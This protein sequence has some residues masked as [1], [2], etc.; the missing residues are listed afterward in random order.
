ME[1]RMR[2]LAEAVLLLHLGFIVFVLIGALLVARWRWLTVL[3]L[4]AVLW[5]LFIEISGGTC[6]L[7]PAENYF[8]HQAGQAGY[9][10]SFI[11]HYLVS[12]IYPAGLTPA[13]QWALAAVVLM[14]NLA[15]YGW[16]LLRHRARSRSG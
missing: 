7:T 9:A 11:E 6:P 2:Y 8:R 10:E 5:A 4:P 1:G 13:I 12:F 15:L 3:H 16:I 14:L